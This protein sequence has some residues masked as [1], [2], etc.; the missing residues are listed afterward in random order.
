[1]GKLTT[2]QRD[3][4]PKKDFAGPHNSYP[5]LDASHAVNAKARASEA[6]HKG[7]MSKVEEEKIDAK[8]NKV[9]GK[10]RT[11]AETVYPNYGKK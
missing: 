9:M 5:V 1:M 11:A 3:A 2:A 4:L 8:A 7:R 6:V 10:K